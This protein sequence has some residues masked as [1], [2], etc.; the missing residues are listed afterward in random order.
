MYIGPEVSIKLHEDVVAQ[1]HLTEGAEISESTLGELKNIEI[2]KEAV[3][4]AY[5]F[6]SYRTLTTV[7]MGERLKRKGFAK[8][9]IQ[10]AIEQLKA[11]KL[12]N[13]TEF[14][15]SFVEDRLKNKLIGE[16][17]LHEDLVHKGFDRSEAEKIV[18]NVKGEADGIP[19]EDE[20]AFQSIMRRSRQIKEIDMH[21]Q[22]RRLYG[23][24]VRQGFAPDVVERA[25]NRFRKERRLGD[26]EEE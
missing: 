15:K 16:E 11:Q 6:L 9:V 19:S 13:D 3:E 22:H 21:T 2:Q 25:I 23:H 24:L 10:V 18:K 8:D 1:F 4:Y 20:R 12:L 14:A 26:P 7:E 5:L 17:R